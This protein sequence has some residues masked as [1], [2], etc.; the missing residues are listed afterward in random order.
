MPALFP[1][2]LAAEVIPNPCRSKED[3]LM[4]AAGEEHAAGFRYWKKFV[5]M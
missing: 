1:R 4:V 3:F 5:F 2:H